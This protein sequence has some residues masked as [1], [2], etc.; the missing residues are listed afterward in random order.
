MAGVPLPA[1]PPTADIRTTSDVE[2]I[3]RRF[4][5]AAIPDPLLGP[6]FETAEIDWSVHVPVVC[7]FWERERLGL[8]VGV[9]QHS[10]ALT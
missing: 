2:L 8:P 9:P 7:A 3:V 6:L 10:G 5:Q 1:A 4:Y